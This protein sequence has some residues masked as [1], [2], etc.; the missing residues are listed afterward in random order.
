LK[1]DANVSEVAR[2]HGRRCRARPLVSKGEALIAQARRALA[3]FPP[4]PTD[5]TFLAN[6]RLVLEKQAN[7]F[8]ARRSTRVEPFNR[9]YN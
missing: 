1:P 5:A 6:P 3:A 7:T 9:W 4:D 2:R 8:E